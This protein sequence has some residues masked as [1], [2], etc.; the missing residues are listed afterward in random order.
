VHDHIDEEDEE[1]E[2]E[3][4]ERDLRSYIMEQIN[5]LN[6]SRESHLGITSFLCVLLACLMFSRRDSIAYS[7]LAIIINVI[8]YGFRSLP[9]TLN[10]ADP[11]ITIY[12]VQ[13]FIY[14]LCIIYILLF[15]SEPTPEDLMRDTARRLQQV[16]DL[17]LQNSSDVNATVRQMFQDSIDQQLTRLME[18][19]DGEV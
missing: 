6:F 4:E 3:G 9:F 17:I 19:Q 11:I 10:D 16:T 18:H 2:E 8:L 15:T 13:Q 14:I 7:P 1:D 12:R 5:G